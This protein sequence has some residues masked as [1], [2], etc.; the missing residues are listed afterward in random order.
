MCLCSRRHLCPSIENGRDRRSI[1]KL[2]LPVHQ[3]YF[4]IFG[5]LILA[6]TVEFVEDGLERYESQHIFLKH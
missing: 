4:F 2:R 6:N 5:L 3:N 1:V